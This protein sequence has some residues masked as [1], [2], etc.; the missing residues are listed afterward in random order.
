MSGGVRESEAHSRF[1]VA[2]RA[3]LTPLV[4]RD[5]EVEL[6]L[7]RWEQV[8][9]GQGQV[10]LL[11]GEA[12]IGKSRLVQELKERVARE[13]YTRIE[14]RCSPYYQNTRFYPVLEHVQV[15]VQFRPDAS[16]Q[17]PPSQPR[18]QARA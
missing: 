10:V 17:Q 6:L 2:V 1:E 16:P 18:E 8:K 15:V 3:G 9:G 7:K 4:G 5:E 14:L 12:G 13:G 11:R